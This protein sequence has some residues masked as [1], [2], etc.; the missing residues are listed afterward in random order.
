VGAPPRSQV[1]GGLRVG[2]EGEESEGRQR[3]EKGLVKAEAGRRGAAKVKRR[4]EGE[5]V[6]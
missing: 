4:E 2:L 5:G 6:A 1:D 3:K